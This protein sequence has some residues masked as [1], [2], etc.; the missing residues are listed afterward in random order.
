LEEVDGV[1]EED[2]LLK[3]TSMSYSVTHD[4]EGAKLALNRKYREALPSATGMH[5]HTVP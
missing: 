4:L 3:I 2:D 1:G 5:A